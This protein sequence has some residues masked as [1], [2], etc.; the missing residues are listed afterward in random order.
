MMWI[1]DDTLTALRVHLPLDVAP[2]VSSKQKVAS[3]K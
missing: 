2:T 3:C 1:E